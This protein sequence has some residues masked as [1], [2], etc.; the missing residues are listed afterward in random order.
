MSA[1]ERLGINAEDLAKKKNHSDFQNQ[2]KN[3]I[4]FKWAK[5][6]T[7]ESDEVKANSRR[8]LFER[9]CDNKAERFDEWLS[10]GRKI[11][12]DAGCGSGFSAMLFSVN[13]LRHTIILE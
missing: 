11:I 5:R 9:Y 6:D 7:Y 1:I 13:I 4:G 12:V 10:D 2:R 8:W 3:T